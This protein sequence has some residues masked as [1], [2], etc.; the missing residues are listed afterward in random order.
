MVLHNFFSANQETIVE[1]I[2]FV[3]RVFPHQ[4]KTNSRPLLSP[5]PVDGGL[6]LFSFFFILNIY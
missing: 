2:G 3:K 1:L 6:L 5:L 4:H